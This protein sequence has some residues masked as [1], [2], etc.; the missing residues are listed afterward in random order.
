MARA[1]ADRFFAGAGCEPFPFSCAIAGEVPRSRGLGSSVTVRLGVLHGLNAM[2]ER[3]A[4]ARGNFSASAPSWRAIRTTPRRRSLAA[5]SSRGPIGISVSR[6]IPRCILSCSSRPL[7]CRTDEARRVL[8]NE[9]DRLRAVESCGN[10]CLITA[11]MASGHY[12]ALRG[13]WRDHLH[14]PFRAKFVPFLDQ[15]IAAAEKAG[16]LGGF[17]SGSGSTIAAV[18][19]RAPRR[20]RRRHA[21]ARPACPTAETRV[22]RGR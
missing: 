10:A 9:I 21:R 15:V 19:L 4:R 1:A 6:S 11:A 2:L 14:Q 22:T 13:A 18:T 3:A 16:A 5:L 17:L 20:S 12:E 7:K 8:P